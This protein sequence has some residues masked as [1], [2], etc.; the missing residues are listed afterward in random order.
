M[1]RRNLAGFTAAT[2]LMSACTPAPQSDWSLT[3][4][5]SGVTTSL[6][7][8][9]VVDDD[10]VWIGAPDGQVLRTRDGGAHWQVGTVALAQGAD[11]RSA[12]GFDD[13]HALFVTA[14][15]PARIIE[16]RDGGASFRLVWEDGTGAAFF[17]SLAFWDAER[18]LA[19]SDPVD[20]AFLVLRTLDGGLTWQSLEIGPVPLESEAGFAASN[21]SIGLTPDGCAFIGTGGAA[22]ARILRTCDFGDTWDAHETPM[23]AGS[24]GAGIFA[25]SIGPDDWLALGGGDYQAAEEPAGNFTYSRDRGETWQ[26]SEAPPRGYRSDLAALGDSWVAVGTTGVDIGVRTGTGFRWQA[27][28]WDIPAPNAIAV[29]PSGETAWIIG[30]SGGIWRVEPK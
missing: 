2:A 24:A 8:L 19:F 27:S 10:I 11:L 25:V 26:T 15:Q 29:S 16:T 9:S 22:V 6:R 23:A 7:G 30:A 18:G 13:Q 4:Q 20:G 1:K 21:S 5:E 14:G 12:H 17:D 3:R 28:G